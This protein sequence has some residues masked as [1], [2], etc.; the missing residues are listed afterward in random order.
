VALTVR[1]HAGL[2]PRSA[3]AHCGWEARIDIGHDC[4]WREEILAPQSKV[5]LL[6]IAQEALAN[7]RKHSRAT[8]VRVSINH[9]GGS[10]RFAIADN[11]GGFDPDRAGEQCGHHGLSMMR[12][13]A[14]EIG[15]ELHIEP[16]VPFDET[17]MN[18]TMGARITA[19]VA[20]Q[21][22]QTPAA[23]T[24]FQGRAR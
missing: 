12:E 18:E 19:I 16:S 1:R 11:G 14:E 4:A 2:S 3:S 7:A 22:L 20:L 5:Q 8:R 23:E 13:R 24:L 6:R 21:S 17:M 9:S 15:A 10:L